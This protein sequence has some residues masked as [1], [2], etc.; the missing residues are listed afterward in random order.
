MTN[1]DI[2]EKKQR[3]LGSL[4]CCCFKAKSKELV[5]TNADEFKPK[6]QNKFEVICLPKPKQFHFVNLTLNSNFLLVINL[7]QRLGVHIDDVAKWKSRH[8]CYEI[9]KSQQ[10][11]AELI[12]D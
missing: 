10:I 1:N 2:A 8:D 5:G 3:G 7:L 6:S 11:E 9:P 12:N 4:L